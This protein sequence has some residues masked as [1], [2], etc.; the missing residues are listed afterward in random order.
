MECVYGLLL[1]PDYDDPLDSTLVLE[2]YQGSGTFSFF[3]SL[4]TASSPY[5]LLILH[6]VR[7]KFVIRVSHFL[8]IRK[9]RF[10]K[11]IAKC[12]ELQQVI[13]NGVMMLNKFRE[14]KFR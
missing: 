9:L 12:S 13:A 2:F 1:T 6:V 3:L 5:H 10:P 8:L 4:S 11:V 7:K 14:Y